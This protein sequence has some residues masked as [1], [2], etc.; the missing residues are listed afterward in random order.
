M[1]VEIN[2]EE[3]AWA[4]GFF[5]GEGHTRSRPISN[6]GRQSPILSVEQV[7]I[8]ALQRFHKAVLG[9]GRMYGPYG[10][11]Q[12]NKQPYYRW[13]T[14]N[15]PESIAACGLLWNWL[16][17]VKRGQMAARFRLHW[18]NRGAA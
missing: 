4:A 13:Q 1:S 3:L 10:P 8:R 2:R 6:R 7:D 9:V 16:G 15:L 12:G 11:Y 17:P 5:D 14:T 18:R